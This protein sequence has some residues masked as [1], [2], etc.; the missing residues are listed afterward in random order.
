VGEHPEG[1]QSSATFEKKALSADCVKIHWV[2][3]RLQLK[4]EGPVACGMSYCYNK[5]KNI[6]KDKIR[7]CKLLGKKR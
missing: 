5:L 2:V 7:L 6:N 3:L 1:V 4:S